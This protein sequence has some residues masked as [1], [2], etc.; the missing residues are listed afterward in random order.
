MRS[1]QAV[2]AALLALLLLAGCA[3]APLE[4]EADQAARRFYAA[5]GQGDWVAVEAGLSPQVASAGAV[6]GFQSASKAIPG[7]RLEESR[8]VGWERTEQDGRKRTSAVHLYRYPG[9]DL[10]VRTVLERTPPDNTYRVAGFFVNR[11]P[12]GMIEASRFTLS[13]KT[14][15][16]YMFLATAILSPLVMIGVA[17]MA[18]F[19][20]GLTWK[21]LW[22]PICLV[23]V[24]TAWMNWTTGEG[25]FFAAQISLINVGVAR[26]TDISPWILKFSAPVGAIVT[27]VRLGL[28]K[29]PSPPK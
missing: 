22:V 15:R 19:T 2:A 4:T 26:A 5:V 6:Q 3:R 21:F 14:M 7:G 24:G 17:L 1:F 9:A 20:P 23:G 29:A 12:P 8:T 11:M 25:G 18:L 10:V 28:H 27:L 16:H 13:G